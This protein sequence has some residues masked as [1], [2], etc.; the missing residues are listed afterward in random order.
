MRPGVL[1]RLDDARDDLEGQDL[2]LLEDVERD[3]YA[4]V[5][6]EPDP[7][8]A[9]EWEG[10]PA[11]T[12]TIGLGTTAGPDLVVFGVTGEAARELLAGAVR[13]LA[14]GGEPRVET[15]D[16]GW[17]PELFGFGCWFYK[18]TDF[19]VLQLVADDRLAPLLDEPPAHR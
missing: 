16:P 19:T 3:G 15:V 1:T 6:V 18:G 8:G 17:N 5:A 9:P 12:Y 2:R 11:W 7:A 14:E 4:T 13:S 10:V